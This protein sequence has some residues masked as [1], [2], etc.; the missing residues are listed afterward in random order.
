MLHTPNKDQTHIMHFTGAVTV[1]DKTITFGVEQKEHKRS[2]YSPDELRMKLNETGF[3]EIA[4]SETFNITECLAWEWDRFIVYECLCAK[5]DPATAT[6][7]PIRQNNL[8][9]IQK[10][11]MAFNPTDFRNLAWLVVAK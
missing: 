8:A 4:I 6:I 5:K 9:Y 2:G 1:R 3:S 10:Q 7:F 11:V